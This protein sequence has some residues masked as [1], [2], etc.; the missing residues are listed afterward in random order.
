MAVFIVN[1]GPPGQGKSLEAARRVQ[2]LVD[3]NRKYF[4]RLTVEY[5]AALDSWKKSRAL[6]FTDEDR[7]TFERE[8]PKPE[9]PRRRVVWSNVKFSPTFEKYAGEFLGYWTDLDQLVKLRDADILWDEIATELDSRNW[10]N[11]SNEVLR[12]LSQYRKRG[13]DIYA[14]TQDF[15]MVDARARIMITRVNTMRKVIGSPD[16]SAT[17]PKPK[18]VWGL[19]VMFKVENWK[20]VDQTKKKYSLPETTCFL[21]TREL[22]E[23]YDTTQDI[24]AGKL[25]AFK[26]EERHCDHCDFKKTIHR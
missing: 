25:P 8:S 11:L 17:K 2:F 26:H 6:R 5:H 3:R 9:H 16:I 24:P 12:F 7:A 18:R 10:A 20:E 1:E 4:D 15:S 21:I 14:N 19:I 23:R 13:I 22:V